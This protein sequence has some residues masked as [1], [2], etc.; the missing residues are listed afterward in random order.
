MSQMTLGKQVAWNSP[1]FCSISRVQHHHNSKWIVHINYPPHTHTHGC[2]WRARVSV[3]RLGGFWRFFVTIW[4]TKIGQVFGALWAILK[5]Y[6]LSKNY[7]DYFLG[8]FWK[9]WLCLSDHTG[10]SHDL[11]LHNAHLIC[12][13]VN[14]VQTKN[15]DGCLMQIQ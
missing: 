3:T 11:V 6:F 12:N 7:C 1:R 14:Y 9:Y 13:G 15:N 8:N 5:K 4:F 10:Q 2:P